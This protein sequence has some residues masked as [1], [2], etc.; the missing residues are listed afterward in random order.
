MSHPQGSPGQD[1]W[2]LGDTNM[3]C[4][5][6][7]EVRGGHTHCSGDAHFPV[8]HFQNRHGIMP[9]TIK[10]NWARTLSIHFGA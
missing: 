1:M 2:I 10:P 3:S 5:A 4:G 9:H 8:Q 6:G 7:Q